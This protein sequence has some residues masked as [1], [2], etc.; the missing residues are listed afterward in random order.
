MNGLD[1]L[2]ATL[3]GLLLRLGIPLL[4]TALIVLWLRRL[5]AHWQ[6]ESRQARVRVLN[7]DEIARCPRCW[8]VRN[9]SPERIADC[10]A[11]ARPDVP[12]WQAF[13]GA[14]GRL[15]EACLNCEVFRNAPVP[16]VHVS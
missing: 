3:V 1:A 11:A 7:V 14:D 8:E 15:L 16:I 10:P 2:A 4:V 9:C 6:A 5:D 13:R 12:C